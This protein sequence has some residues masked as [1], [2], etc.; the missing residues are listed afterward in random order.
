MT[1]LVCGCD[2]VT[3]YRVALTQGCG[4]DRRAGGPI[5]ASGRN[6]RTGTRVQGSLAWHKAYFVTP[7]SQP[8]LRVE[9]VVVQL[10]SCFVYLLALLRLLKTFQFH[11]RLNVITKTLTVA[12]SDLFHFCIIFM[13]VTA[14]YAAIAVTT[15]GSQLEEYHSFTKA[16][17]TFMRVLLGDFSYDALVLVAPIMGPIVFWSFVFVV[18][19]ILLNVFLSIVGTPT[20]APLLHGSRVLRI[21][22]HG[23]PVC[24]CVCVMCSASY[25]SMPTSW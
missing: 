2:A 16:Y 18:F 14:L 17:E 25:Q 7:H 15:F 1:R 11:D 4:L 23:S 12:A 5:I 21:W 10:I 24:V 22:T 9:R 13:A 20:I 6:C 3:A 8:M 19:F